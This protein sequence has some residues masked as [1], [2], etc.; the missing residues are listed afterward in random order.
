MHNKYTAS[1]YETKTTAT[2]NPFKKTTIKNLPRYKTCALKYLQ[3][4]E[5]VP[6]YLRSWLLFH[7]VSYFAVG[8]YNILNLSFSIYI[9]LNDKLD[10]K[11]K[12]RNNLF[13]PTAR[14]C[15][16]VCVWRREREGKRE[17]QNNKKKVIAILSGGY[18]HIP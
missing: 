5:H 15:V 11:N 17:R 4:I 10:G 8:I 18:K 13:E 16:R 7:F 9:S 3:P 6:I 12:R 1:K 2:N 14:L